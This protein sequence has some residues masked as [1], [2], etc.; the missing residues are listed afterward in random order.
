MVTLIDSAPYTE[1]QDSDDSF[2]AAMTANAEFY[3]GCKLR[4]KIVRD[5]F[6][7]L[8]KCFGPC[9]LLGLLVITFFNFSRFDLKNRLGC[10]SITLL[11]YI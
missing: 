5:P 2:D 4:F 11:T 7:K 1:D 6:P 9:M 10:V 8:V 3:P